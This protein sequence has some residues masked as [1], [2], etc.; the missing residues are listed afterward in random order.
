MFKKRTR[1]VVKQQTMFIIDKLAV[2]KWKSTFIL[3]IVSED[4]NDFSLR[5]QEKTHI[6][7]RIPNLTTTQALNFKVYSVQLIES[8]LINQNN[9]D[10]K[11]IQLSWHLIQ[12]NFKN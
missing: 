2:L 4:Q 11:Q 9:F 8:E 12:L 10:F 5:N 1:S 7:R 3:G 6:I